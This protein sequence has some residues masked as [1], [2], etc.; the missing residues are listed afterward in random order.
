MLTSV[1]DLFN[2]PEAMEKFGEMVQLRVYGEGKAEEHF[3]PKAY[4][5]RRSKDD[6]ILIVGSSNL[7]EKGLLNRVEWNLYSSGGEELFRQARER[8]ESYWRTQSFTP[9][10]A[11]FREYRRRRAQMQ[12]PPARYSSDAAGYGR[13]PEPNRFQREALEQLSRLRDEGIN[14]AAVVAA[15]GSGKTFL[16]AFDFRGSGMGNIL[17]IAHR[18]NILQAS[19]E[20]FLS[21]AGGRMKARTIAGV[22]GKAE[23]G[24]SQS[25]Q[26]DFAMVQTMSK[27][28]VLE[29]YPADHYDYIL[30]DEFH[31]A[32]AESYRRILAHFRPRFLLGLTATPERMDGRDVLAHCDHNLAYEIRLFDAVEAGLLA[33]FQYFAIYDPVDY[34]Q[35]RWNGMHYDPEELEEALSDDNRAQLVLSN[36]HRYLPAD[37]G[38]IKAL[39]FCANRGHARYMTRRFNEL[40]MPAE[41]VLGDTTEDE[42]QRLIRR[43]A[44]EEDPLAVLFSVDV[45]SEGIDIP[46]L[47]HILLLR[48]TESMTV[49]QQQ[50]GRGLRRA[51]GKEFVVIL[52]FI[53]NYR[54]SFIPYLAL[55]GYTRLSGMPLRA[56][57]EDPRVPDPCYVA[58]DTEVRRIQQEQLKKLIGGRRDRR[59]LCREIYREVREDEGRSL[60]L[61]DLYVHPLTD[62]VKPFFKYL[63][64][65]WLRIKEAMGDLSE[66]ER[67]LLDSPAERLLAHIES[68]LKPNKS[69]K[70]V[71]LLSLVEKEAGPEGWP[72]SEIAENFKRFYLE[73]RRYLHDY[74]EMA[75]SSDPEQ[76]PLSK[77]EAHIKKMPLYYLSDKD[78]K[79]FFLDEP[80]GRF[81][82]KEEYRP[83]WNDEDFKAQVRDRV[84]YVLKSYFFRSSR[85]N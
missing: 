35:I 20:T 1:M 58:E 25:A 62:E 76:F 59:E 46:R 56:T 24:P 75:R 23:R 7:T 37:G 16:A 80:A 71:V 63:G 31:H 10:E 49:F 77:V 8:F 5:F 12:P 60:G 15:P 74:N 83:Y 26:M 32:E 44:D 82:L 28:E 11:F 66:E 45:F 27:A 4:L 68:E 79:P 47:S 14:K 64:A 19:K 42:R 48:P 39:G 55:R 61:T 21:V 53:G 81:Y 22:E 36:L 69:Y 17:Y 73:N 3:H 70:M 84:R 40:G 18:Y 50:L 85:G 34:R 33:P 2:S 29:R 13:P 78:E 67:A 51:P 43:L 72:T 54:T 57:I 9:D 41:A 30:V 6:G 52:D 65:N 38:K